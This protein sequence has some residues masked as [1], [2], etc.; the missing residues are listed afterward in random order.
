MGKSSFLRRIRRSVTRN[1]NP[2]KSAKD[3]SDPK[4][5]FRTNPMHATSM[6]M[7]QMSQK[8]S[9]KLGDNK[10]FGKPGERNFLQE[11]MHKVT[12]GQGAMVGTL[13]GSGIAAKES[14]MYMLDPGQHVVGGSTSMDADTKHFVEK[15]E[16]ELQQQTA[17]EARRQKEAEHAYARSES[18]RVF[19]EEK[20]KLRTRRGATAA[21]Y[22]TGWK[23]TGGGVDD[24]ENKST[25]GSV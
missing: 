12:I 14:A 8:E 22:L 10:L 5:L 17:E 6:D 3:V 13:G 9:L 4:D 2:M 16:K 1:L 18:E 15:A 11:A 21:S 19:E 25:L 24:K 23:R 7:A 20:K